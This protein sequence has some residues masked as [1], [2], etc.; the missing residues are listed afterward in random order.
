[1]EIV[2]ITLIGILALVLLLVLS[3]LP[4]VIWRYWLSPHAELHTALD[5]R[6][7]IIDDNRKRARENAYDSFAISVTHMEDHAK[8]DA[9]LK[10][11][12][13]AIEDEYRREKAKIE[14]IEQTAKKRTPP[15]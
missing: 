2:G 14:E 7:A 3:L 9:E 11:R 5:R 6:R 1:M 8:A 10:E 4:W 15:A 12:L 13:A